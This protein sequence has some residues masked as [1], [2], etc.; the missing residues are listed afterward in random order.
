MTKDEMTTV[1]CRASEATKEY[2]RC[3]E[4]AP[5]AKPRTTKAQKP[6]FGRKGVQK[7]EKTATGNALGGNVKS[8]PQRELEKHKL[9]EVATIVELR[10]IICFVLI[11]QRE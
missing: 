4:G 2:M 7:N 5:K 9:Q 3:S 11:D 1:L 8:T 6:T 10:F